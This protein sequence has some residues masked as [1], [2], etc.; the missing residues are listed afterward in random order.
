MSPSLLEGFAYPT[1]F[2]SRKIKSPGVEHLREKR[3]KNSSTP[4]PLHPEISAIL[5]LFFGLVVRRRRRVRPV[6]LKQASVYAEPPSSVC[7]VPRNKSTSVFFSQLS[8]SLSP[9]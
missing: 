4:F 8:L 9:I 2:I 1:P 5:A 3:D 7:V 6:L